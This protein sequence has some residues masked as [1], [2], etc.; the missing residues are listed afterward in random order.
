[1]GVLLV[2]YHHFI[3]KQFCEHF[4][5]YQIAHQWWDQCQLTQPLY[6]ACLD[7]EYDA[8]GL[9][10]LVA[11]A[12]MRTHLKILQDE[13]IWTSCRN[14]YSERDITIVIG[15]EGALLCEWPD[16]VPSRWETSSAESS[17]DTLLANTSMESGN[18][19]QLNSGV[20]ESVQRLVKTLGGRPCMRSLH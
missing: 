2:T 19:Q 1:M 10:V 3:R 18:V 16:P 7:S 4:Q 15:V 11:L 9:E 8:D 17:A 14:D 5:N 13:Q 20:P 12:A 6:H